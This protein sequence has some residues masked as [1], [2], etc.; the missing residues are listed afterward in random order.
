MLKLMIEPTP[1]TFCCSL[2]VDSGLL[3]ALNCATTG[4]SGGHIKY[5]EETEKKLIN[6]F[7]NKISNATMADFNFRHLTDP[8]DWNKIPKGDY[9]TANGAFFTLLYRYNQLAKKAGKPTITTQDIVNFIKD[10][11][12]RH[13]SLVV[14]GL[15]AKPGHETGNDNIPVVEIKAPI[16][17]LLK[18]KDLGILGATT[19]ERL[20]KI[21]PET[22]MY[23][24][25][26]FRPTK[27]RDAAGDLSVIEEGIQPLSFHR[28]ADSQN[29]STDPDDSAINKAKRK[30]WDTNYISPD[31]STRAPKEYFKSQVK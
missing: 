3:T 9:R 27:S 6:E 23:I 5:D 25:I 31:I 29:T 13:N 28:D 24:K 19:E 8:D 20:Q 18:G 4:K 16:S 2:F 11:A 21:G 15:T 7:Q 26:A 1:I 17:Q 22:D 30:A 12:T 14:K 10:A